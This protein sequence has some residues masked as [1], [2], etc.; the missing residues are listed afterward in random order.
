LLTMV[1]DAKL[2][3]LSHRSAIE[4]VPLQIYCSALVYSPSK[5]V[6]RCQFLDQK[7]VWIEKPPVTQEVWDLALQVLEGH[8]KWVT[9]VAFSPD[10]Q[11]LATASYNHTVRFWNL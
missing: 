7:P 1:H 8:S 5:S 6:I 11:I 10:D 4:S 2:F 3:V 9:A